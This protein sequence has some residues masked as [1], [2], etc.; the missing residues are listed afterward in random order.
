MGIDVDLA[1]LTD[2]YNDMIDMSAEAG[3]KASDATA[4]NMGVDSTIVSSTDT[5]SDTV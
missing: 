5:A 3:A 4:S 1:P 2:S